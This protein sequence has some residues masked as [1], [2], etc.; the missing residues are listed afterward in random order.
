[1]GPVEV[2]NPNKFQSSMVS[3]L[4][5]N[6]LAFGRVAFFPVPRVSV[7]KGEEKNTSRISDKGISNVKHVKKKIS[8]SGDKALTSYPSLSYFLPLISQLSCH[9]P[10][11]K[12]LYSCAHLPNCL[13]ANKAQLR[14]I[15]PSVLL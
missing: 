9:H 2:Q 1:M 15:T 6:I 12:P 8:L 14:H 10:E 11:Q 3:D 4:N 7:I 13:T 5:Q